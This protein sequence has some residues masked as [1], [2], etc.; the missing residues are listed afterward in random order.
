M[1]N[2]YFT[3]RLALHQNKEFKFSKNQ[4]DKMKAKVTRLNGTEEDAEGADRVLRPCGEKE[5][6]FK[7]DCDDPFANIEIKRVFTAEAAEGVKRRQVGKEE[8]AARVRKTRTSGAQEG[9]AGASSNLSSPSPAKRNIY[10]PSFQTVGRN[11]RDLL[12]PADRMVRTGSVET[13]LF[14]SLARI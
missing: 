10:T 11:Q 13:R 8:E 12:N 14:F 3:S 9:G 7:Y 5:D 1:I 2:Y 4:L 6:M